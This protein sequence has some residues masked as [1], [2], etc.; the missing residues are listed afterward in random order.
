MNKIYITIIL[1]LSVAVSSCND[2][3]NKPQSSTNTHNTSQPSAGAYTADIKIDPRSQTP[4]HILNDG[5]NQSKSAH[6][7]NNPSFVRDTS[8]STLKEELTDT[9]ENEQD[10]TNETINEAVD[11]QPNN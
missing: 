7:E 4:P 9:Y 11:R 1:G 10:T 3:G 2:S 8:Q 5:N 6:T